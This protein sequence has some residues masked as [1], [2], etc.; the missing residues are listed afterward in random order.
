MANAYE[1]IMQDI[2][3]GLGGDWRLGPNKQVLE[4]LYAIARKAED[5]KYVDAS[6]E[7][8]GLLYQLTHDEEIKSKLEYLSN[9]SSEGN[10]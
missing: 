1:Q 4:I 3:S 7:Y 10:A 8:Y 2:I 5:D 9:L 6:V